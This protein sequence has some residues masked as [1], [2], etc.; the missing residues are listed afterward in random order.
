MD[1]TLAGLIG[2]ALLVVFIF[3]GVPV[4][5]TMALIGFGGYVVILGLDKA[6]SNMALIA[7]DTAN[8]YSFAVIPLFLLMSAFVSRSGI[9]KEAYKTAC[10]W[11]GQ[12]K[13]GLAMA[14]TVACGLFAACCGSSLAAAIAMG[15]M[16]YPEM[17][18]YGESR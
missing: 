8:H 11:V 9:G 10:A 3:S 2:I 15:K 1:P 18:S 13:G 6:L 14:T 17:K 16:A 4:G 7:F 5:V 12:L